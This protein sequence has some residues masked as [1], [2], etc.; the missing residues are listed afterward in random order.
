[1][2]YKN[3]LL[4]DDDQDD[5]EIFSAA[6]E[7]VS[8]ELI[9]NARSSASEALEQ[10]ILNILTP[11]LIFLDLNMPLMNGQEFLEAFRKNER[12]RGIPVIILSTSSNPATIKTTKELGAFD[13]ITKPSRFDSLVVILKSLLS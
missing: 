2:G 12:L 8:D 4:I 13:Y 9:Y 1:M 6:V 11:D 3:I 5:Q 7:K 10:L